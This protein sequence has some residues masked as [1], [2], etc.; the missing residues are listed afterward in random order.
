MGGF[1]PDYAGEG[2]KD[3]GCHN[4]S[5][6]TLQQICN[7]LSATVWRLDSAGCISARSPKGAVRQSLTNAEH[8]ASG[9]PLVPRL[10]ALPASA[11][12]NVLQSFARRHLSYHLSS[13]SEQLAAITSTPDMHSTAP[14][15]PLER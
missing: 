9:L 10:A 7:K 8:P 5:T 3:D 6:V 12:N 4:C 11:S 14:L 15:P 1:Y 13:A 2:L